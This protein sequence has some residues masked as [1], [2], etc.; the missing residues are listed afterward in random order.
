MAKRAPASK[1][2]REVCDNTPKLSAAAGNQVRL[3]TAGPGISYF[4]RVF[5]ASFPSLG[6]PACP[7]YFL[8]LI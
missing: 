7:S 5:A 6:P 2:R 8:G 1:T 3:T 4:E